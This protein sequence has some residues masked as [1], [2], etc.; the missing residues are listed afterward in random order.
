MKKKGQCASPTKKQQKKHCT[1]PT[2]RR[3]KKKRQHA[4]GMEM[5]WLMIVCLALDEKTS[6][7]PRVRRGATLASIIK[8]IKGDD[9]ARKSDGKKA[10]EAAC[11][12]DEVAEE[13]AALPPT[14]KARRRCRRP[15][16]KKG[17]PAHRKIEKPK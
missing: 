17:Q 2:R 16:K 5:R 11:A 1:R 4:L 9:T 3:K 13:M 8:V 10:E 7:F 15:A 12:P 14:K 6:M